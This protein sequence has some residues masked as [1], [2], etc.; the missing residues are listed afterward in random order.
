MTIF[1]F[2]YIIC[3]RVKNK[4]EI[5]IKGDQLNG[6]QYGGHDFHVPRNGN[7]PADDP[8]FIFILRRDGQGK[9]CSEHNH[10]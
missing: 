3:S 8:S 10:A 4:L 9:K 6:N 5:S 7:G 2:G 1:F